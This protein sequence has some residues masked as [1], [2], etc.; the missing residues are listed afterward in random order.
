MKPHNERVYVYVA[1]PYSH[2]DPVENTH[3]ALVVADLLEAT[4]VVTAYVPHTSLLWHL[5]FPHD[6]D[7]WYDYDIAWLDR[8]DALLR[9]PGESTG[10]DDEVTYAHT[11]EIPVFY[12]VNALLDWIASDD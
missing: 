6:V 1:G 2:P 7:F 5:V 12:S 3:N 4:E 8:C 9:M 10:A 11:Q